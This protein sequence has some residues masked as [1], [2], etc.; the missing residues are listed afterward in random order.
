MQMDY[1]EYLVREIHSTVMATV[2][3]KGLPV[4]CAIDLMDWDEKGIYFL[5]A[6]GKGLYKRLVDSGYVALTGMKGEDTMSCAA[7]SLRGRAEEIGPAPLARLFEL[8]PYMHEIYP[9]EES[10]K[11]LTVFLIREGSGEWFDLSKKPVER[12]VFTFGNPALTEE[13][14]YLITDKCTGCGACLQAC[15]Q[16]CIKKGAPFVIQQEHC[17]HCGN[18]YEM[19]PSAAVERRG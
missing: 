10:R 14:G 6:R 11:A 17:L 18:C 19:C 8:N 5:T 13:E 3:E 9:N 12:A 7:I 4:T 2:D 1:L 16:G 15:P